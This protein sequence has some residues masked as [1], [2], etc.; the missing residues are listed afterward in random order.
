MKGII[1]DTETASLK[2]GVVELASIEVDSVGKVVQN[3]LQCDLVNPQCKISFEAMAIHNITQDMVDN[4]D[5]IEELYEKHQLDGE[6]YIIAHNAKFDIKMLPESFVKPNQK[7][8]CTL[9]LARELYP[10]GDGVGCVESHKLGVLFYQF[11]LDKTF[12]G[13][14]GE[15]HS[16]SYD[17]QVTAEV[18]AYMLAE[19]NLT[20]ESA[21]NLI[22][23][24]IEKTKCFMKKYRETGMTWEEVAKKDKPYVTWLI[25]KF[26]WGDDNDSLVDYLKLNV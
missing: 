15:F 16:A 13:N 24:P 12:K 2:G 23:K 6:G 5:T 14:N 18:L 11:G 20:L 21:Y 10:K 4:A 26:E 25:N 17:V 7:V 19:N 8:L 22:N 9:E 3:T 1:I